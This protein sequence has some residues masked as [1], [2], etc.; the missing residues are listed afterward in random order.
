MEQDNNIQ[1]NYVAFGSNYAPYVEVN[2]VS[3]EEVEIRG[4]NWIGWGTNNDYPV[5][6][7][8]LFNEVATL[9]TLINSVCD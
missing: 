2:K 9:R 8:T 5:Y 3:S 7:Y 4:K 6:L 1:K